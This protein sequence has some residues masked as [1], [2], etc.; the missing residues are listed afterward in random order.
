MYTK[1]LFDKFD[2]NSFVQY[3]NILFTLLFTM[4]A[5]LKILALKGQYFRSPWN[6]FD[7]LVLVLSV[8]GM[9]PFGLIEYISVKGEL[10]RIFPVSR[11]S[12]LWILKQSY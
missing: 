7:L 1:H 5:V 11:A 2:L 8:T 3:F 6:D 9:S 12:A 10:E 4:E